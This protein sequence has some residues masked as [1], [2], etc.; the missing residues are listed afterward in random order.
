MSFSL[1]LYNE[2]N[3]K[4]NQLQI[5]Y[6]SIQTLIQN[7]LYHQKKKSD[8][9]DLLTKLSKFEEN[10]HED[11]IIARLIN[12]S[13]E[14]RQCLESADESIV[15]KRLPISELQKNFQSSNSTRVEKQLVKNSLVSYFQTPIDKQQE[16]I[17][18]LSVL[19]EFTQ[20]EY[21][22]AMNAISNNYANSTALAR[23]SSWIGGG[24]PVRAKLS[25]SIQPDKSFTEL[26]IQYVDQKLPTRFNP[27]VSNAK[28]STNEQ[29]NIEQ[30]TSPS[31]Q[32]LSINTDKLVTI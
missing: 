9:N 23:L 18:T 11:S 4:Y 15:N 1:T 7:L 20:D 29:S 17:P 19:V 14:I 2:L 30:N 25:S 28:S 22:K 27:D 16:V 24:Y 31:T 10:T 8:D 6:E 26:L 32:S 21:D 12:E 3:T 5:Y 13:N